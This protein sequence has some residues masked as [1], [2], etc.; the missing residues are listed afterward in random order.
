MNFDVNYLKYMY[1]EK[2]KYTTKKLLSMG[3]KIFTLYV[4][5]FEV[6]L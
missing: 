2:E 1:L 5:I 6:I 3:G 4:S